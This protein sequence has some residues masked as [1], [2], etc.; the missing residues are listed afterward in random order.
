MVFSGNSKE[1]LLASHLDS[2]WID[3]LVDSHLD[4]GVSVNGVDK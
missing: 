4:I 3:W 2:Q 1:T